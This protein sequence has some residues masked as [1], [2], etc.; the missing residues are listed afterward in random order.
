MKRLLFL[1]IAIAIIGVSPAMAKEIKTL[2]DLIKAYDPS[3]CK[4]CHKK[5]YEDWEKS[6]H[7]RPLLGPVGRTLA[8]FQG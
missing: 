1:I 2:N 5:I 3:S 4:E 8:T 7:A 6:L